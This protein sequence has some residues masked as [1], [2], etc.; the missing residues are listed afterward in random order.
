MLKNNGQLKKVEGNKSQK[1]SD[2]ISS[3]EAIPYNYDEYGNELYQNQNINNRSMPFNEKNSSEN[4]SNNN[5]AANL[6]Q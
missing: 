5:V 1:Q 6:N 4:N 3:Q 2:Q